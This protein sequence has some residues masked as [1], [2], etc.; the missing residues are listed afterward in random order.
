VTG[1]GGHIRLTGNVH[2]LRDRNIAAATAWGAAGVTAV[3]N[4][5]TVG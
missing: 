1:E 3:Q 5:I 2:Y 4:D